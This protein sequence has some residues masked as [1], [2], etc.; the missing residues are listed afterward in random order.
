MEDIA[1]ARDRLLSIVS[2][3]QLQAETMQEYCSG[4]MPTWPE[5]IIL[6]FMACIMI[7]VVSN[8]V[9]AP[10]KLRATLSIF[11]AGGILVVTATQFYVKTKI[12]LNQQY[13]EW[14]RVA[15]KLDLL[16]FHLQFNHYGQNLD[17]KE[18]LAS[19][20][21]VF[22]TI[23]FDIQLIKGPIVMDIEKWKNCVTTVNRRH[24]L[25][26]DQWIRPW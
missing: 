7:V 12:E 24:G 15:G 21:A 6:A 1:A 13:R 23:Q 10:Y 11:L 4:G 2:E 25:P 5:I 18:K 20:N 17:D 8:L 22:D 9:D 16:K 14:Q 19:M 3:K 26:L